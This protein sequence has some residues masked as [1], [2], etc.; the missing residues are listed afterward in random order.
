ML[1]VKFAAF[2]QVS[3][4]RHLDYVVRLV[5]I[6]SAHLPSPAFRSCLLS[7][8]FVQRH[9]SLTRRDW[10]PLDLGPSCAVRSSA[11]GVA[12]LARVPL[13]LTRRIPSRDGSRSRWGESFPLSPNTDSARNAPKGPA[14]NISRMTR[15]G[16]PTCRVPKTA[17]PNTGSTEPSI[18][19]PG[20]RQ[21]AIP[22][23]RESARNPQHSRPRLKS[24]R[25]VKAELGVRAERKISGLA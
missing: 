4:S 8:V 25:A 19:S 23:E 11:L 7:A 21:A 13:F 5:P 17:A 3:L 20:I 2:R 6:L 12:C 18:E 22:S 16:G 24:W 10:Q 14:P 1:R 15:D 9:V